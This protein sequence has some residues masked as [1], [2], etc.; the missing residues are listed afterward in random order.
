MILQFKNYIKYIYIY[1]YM[2]VLPY[3]FRGDVLFVDG[4]TCGVVTNI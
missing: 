1:V 4:D 3:I 2:K